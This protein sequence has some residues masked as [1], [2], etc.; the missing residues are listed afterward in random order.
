[1]SL[2][3]ERQINSLEKL[4]AALQ[5]AG[6]T[7]KPS[8]TLFGPKLATYYVGHVYSSSNS[9]EGVTVGRI[10]SRK[11]LSDYVLVRGRPGA[12]VHQTTRSSL[13]LIILPAL[14]WA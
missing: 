14:I 9:A 5:T 8:K 4:F 1:M 11:R 3:W 6:L 2:A 10:E 12:P 13:R 7:L